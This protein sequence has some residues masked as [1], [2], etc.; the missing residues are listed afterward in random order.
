MQSAHTKTNKIE[1]VS[2]SVSIN[3][4]EIVFI[5][6]YSPKYYASFRNDVQKLTADNR[7]YVIFGDINARHSA[8]NCVSSN[9]AGNILFELQSS[10]NFIIYNPQSPTYIL[11]A[12]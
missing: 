5:S 7:E 2:I 8:W 12:R 6:A 1:N 10:S 9:K 3:G 11:P 4:R